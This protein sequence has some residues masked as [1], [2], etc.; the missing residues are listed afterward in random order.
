MG[1]LK[2]KIKGLGGSI[3]WKNA[4]NY[5]IYKCKWTL[6][7]NSN[8]QIFYRSRD[9]IMQRYKTILKKLNNGNSS[10]EDIRKALGK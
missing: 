2:H 4:H 3:N 1:D 10:Q 5:Y 9:Q 6:K 8:K 7:E